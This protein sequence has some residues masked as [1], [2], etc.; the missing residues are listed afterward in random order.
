MPIRCQVFAYINLHPL[1]FHI[2]IVE[3]SENAS[4]GSWVR[5]L[6]TADYPVEDSGWTFSEGVFL[7]AVG[8]ASFNL[9]LHY[10][11]RRANF[12]HHM[13]F[14][15]ATFVHYH[16]LLNRP[17]IYVGT[18]GPCRRAHSVLIFSHEQEFEDPEFGR[19]PPPPPEP[20][21]S[22]APDSSAAANAV[23][24]RRR[25]QIVNRAFDWRYEWAHGRVP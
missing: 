18:V 23:E 17:G 3:V 12:R 5:F 7:N 9:W 6:S 8:Q 11:G 1:R 25:R 2:L 4:G 14:N 20:P 22:P 21:S 13:F 15:L 19:P 10:A 24:R 16:A